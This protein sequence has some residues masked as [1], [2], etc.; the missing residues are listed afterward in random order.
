MPGI[1]V[2][3]RRGGITWEAKDRI[4][5]SEVVWALV[6]LAVLAFMIWNT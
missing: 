4:N 1:A 6:M 3:V 5:R 2:K